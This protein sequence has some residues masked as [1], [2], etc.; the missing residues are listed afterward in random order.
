MRDVGQSCLDPSEYDGDVA[1]DIRRQSVS[2]ILPEMEEET[3]EDKAFIASQGE[4]ANGTR[5]DS[6][7]RLDAKAEAAEKKRRKAKRANVSPPSKKNAKKRRTRTRDIEKTGT[8]P[9]NFRSSK[10]AITKTQKPILTSA[11]REDIE[12]CISSL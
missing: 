8:L 11:P 4:V 12:V 10:S 2:Y 6:V 7:D 3:E 5:D 9:A 1:N